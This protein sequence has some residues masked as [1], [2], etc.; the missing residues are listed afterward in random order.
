[1]NVMHI[2]SVQLTHTKTILWGWHSISRPNLSRD[3]ASDAAG[4]VILS[5]TGVDNRIAFAHLSADMTKWTM[6]GASP[7]SQQSAW[8][9]SMNA[10]Y[11][12]TAPTHWLAWTGSGTTSDHRLNVR[13]TQQ[14]PSW[15][16]ANT[17]TTLDETA[18]SSPAWA[19]TGNGQSGQALLAWAG[20]DRYHH[21]NIA[22]ISV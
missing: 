6:P 22:V 8:A 12:T 10:A 7:L 15:S 13:Y 5:W 18:I 17:Q 19:F 16:G 1:V 4:P 2:K 21:L 3:L 11:S 20:T 14:Y 9:P